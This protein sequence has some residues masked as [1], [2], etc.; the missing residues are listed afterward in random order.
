[1]S[2]KL[3]GGR[4]VKSSAFSSPQKQR[5]KKRKGKGTIVNGLALISLITLHCTV[6][7]L[8]RE[9]VTKLFHLMEVNETFMYFYIWQ[10]KENTPCPICVH[11]IFFARNGYFY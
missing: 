5:N 10:M 2:C 6:V 1:M 3:Q 7:E 11:S 9:G 8:Y 4:V